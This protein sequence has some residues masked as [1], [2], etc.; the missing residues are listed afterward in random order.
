MVVPV[1]M[2]IVAGVSP[3]SLGRADLLGDRQAVGLVT[4]MLICQRVQVQT[5]GPG[6]RVFGI[7]SFATV[8]V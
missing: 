2:G 4:G 6:F 1:G 7:L 3:S 5:E 8:P